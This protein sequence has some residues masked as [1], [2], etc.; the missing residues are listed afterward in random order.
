MSLGYDPEAIYQ[1]DDIL[2]AQYAQDAQETEQPWPKCNEMY[3]PKDCTEE[4]FNQG[5]CEDHWYEEWDRR[6]PN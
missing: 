2:M 6:H 3:G 1:D 4:V 5:F